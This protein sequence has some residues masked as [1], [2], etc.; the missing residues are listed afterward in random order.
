MSRLRRDQLQG[1]LSRGYEQGFQTAVLARY[2][3]AMHEA[4][5]QPAERRAKI[6]LVQ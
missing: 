3:E 4:E 6:M 5:P 2:D 1:L